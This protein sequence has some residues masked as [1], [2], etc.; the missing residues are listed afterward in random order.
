MIVRDKNGHTVNTEKAFE[1]QTRITIISKGLFGIKKTKKSDYWEHWKYY[2]TMSAVLE[3]L[4][5]YKTQN[6]F[7]DF[8]KNCYRWE[9]RPAHKYYDY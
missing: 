1:I 3:A 8:G 2:K 5:Y 9:F 6:Y 4:K 7:S